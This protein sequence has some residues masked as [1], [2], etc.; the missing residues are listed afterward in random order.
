MKIPK[1]LIFFK[2]KQ[3]L[4]GKCCFGKVQLMPVAQTRNVKSE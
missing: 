3:T 2:K 1:A 4:L